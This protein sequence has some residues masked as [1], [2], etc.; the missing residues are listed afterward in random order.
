MNLQQEMDEAADWRETRALIRRMWRWLR[1]T[2]QPDYSGNALADRGAAWAT[3]QDLYATKA[4]ASIG[5]ME[6]VALASGVWGGD[7]SE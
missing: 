1:R 5:P 2:Y 6:R 7:G 3:L 4:G